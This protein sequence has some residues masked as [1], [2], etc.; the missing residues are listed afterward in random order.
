MFSAIAVFYF[1]AVWGIRGGVQNIFEVV[2]AV[3]Q[4]I[5]ISAADV[6]INLAFELWTQRSPI[7]LQDRAQIVMFLPVCGGGGIDLA[8]FLIEDGLRVA[9][10]A[11]GPVDG[12]PDIELLAR[13]GA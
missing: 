2:D 13:A 11:Y 12:L 5:G 10:L 6:N 1:A 4:K 7:F 3:V 9:V 8:S